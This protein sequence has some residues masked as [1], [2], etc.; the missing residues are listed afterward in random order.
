[1]SS[2]PGGFA[3]LD[4]AGVTEL[5]Q[6]TTGLASWSPNPVVTQAD[7]DAY[8]A[9]RP[10]P[11]GWTATSTGNWLKCNPNSA[12]LRAQN[13]CTQQFSFTFTLPA[14]HVASAFMQGRYSYDECAAPFFS[15]AQAHLI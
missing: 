11:L 10:R 13:G 14:E 12:T 4:V 2:A 9:A 15:C 5:V 6:L 3:S 8:N 1:M 7:I